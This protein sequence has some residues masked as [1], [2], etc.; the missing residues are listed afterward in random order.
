MADVTFILVVEDEPLIHPIVELA[1]KDAGYA[2]R[3]A[4]NGEDAI[5]VLKAQAGRVQVLVT[6]VELRGSVD[7][8]EVARRGR[9]LNDHLPVVYMTGASA[10]DWPS[11]GTP[12]SLLIAKPFA[13]AELV[14]T[15]SM[16]LA[17]TAALP[18]TGS[19]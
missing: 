13:M 5:S 11:R 8:W 14:T 12:N 6:D 18:P 16:L 3:L 9:E 10:H 17:G 2:A 7:G 19:A 15:I 4:F 1:L